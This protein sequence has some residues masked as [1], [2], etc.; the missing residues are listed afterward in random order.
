MFTVHIMDREK[1]IEYFFRGVTFLHTS[2]DKIN[3]STH[4]GDYT[5]PLEYLVAI[6]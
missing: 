5:F 2:G 4:N 6:Y 1:G 3:F